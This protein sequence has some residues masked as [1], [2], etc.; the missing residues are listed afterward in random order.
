MVLNLTS[1]RD[2]NFCEGFGGAYAERLALKQRRINTRCF[3]RSHNGGLNVFLMN[4]VFLRGLFVT[5]HDAGHAF[6]IC[7]F[8]GE[9]LGFIHNNSMTHSRRQSESLSA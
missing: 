1:F 2:A 9:F 3:S 8:F 5:F 6:A 7:R 4:G